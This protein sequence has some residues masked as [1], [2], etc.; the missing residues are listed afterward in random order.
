MAT[1]TWEGLDYV[2]T[3]RFG[4]QDRTWF[5]HVSVTNAGTEPVVVD[6]VLHPRPGAGLV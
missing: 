4:A 2:A 6:V 3:F 1:G 5:W